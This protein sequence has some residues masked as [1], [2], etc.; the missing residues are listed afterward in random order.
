MSYQV[1]ARKW[2]LRKFEDVAG[3]EVLTRTLQNANA[4][5][6]VRKD[7]DDNVIILWNLCTALM[8]RT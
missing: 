6:I 8:V 2:R 4:L 7:L 3:H 5:R 1:I